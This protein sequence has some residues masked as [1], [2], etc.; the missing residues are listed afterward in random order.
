MTI[1]N[2][3]TSVSLVNKQTVDESTIARFDEF[4]SNK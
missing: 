4:Y 3:L 2:Y 1:E